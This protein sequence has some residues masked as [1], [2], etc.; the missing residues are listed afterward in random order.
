MLVLILNQGRGGRQVPSPDLLQTLS[1]IA[2]GSLLHALRALLSQL[3]VP[4]L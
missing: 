3:Y 2:K 4:L 1:L